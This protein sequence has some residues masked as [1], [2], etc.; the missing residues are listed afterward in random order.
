M[1]AIEGDDVTLTCRGTRYLYDRLSW[2]DPQ[3]RPVG[4]DGFTQ[5]VDPYS[6]S[7]SLRLKNVSRSHSTGYQCRAVNL[8]AGK[9]VNITSTLI[10]H[11]EILLPSLR[12][13]PPLSPHHTCLSRLAFR[14][15]TSIS[16]RSVW[17]VYL[18]ATVLLKGDYSALICPERRLPILKQNLTSQD[19]NSSS[20]LTLACLAHGVPRPFITWYKDK[21]LVTEGPGEELLVQ[22]IWVSRVNP[23]IQNS[24]NCLLLWLIYLLYDK[25]TLTERFQESR[26]CAGKF[27]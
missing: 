19:V 24:K 10:I 2:H 18:M 27:R 16:F 22:F 8:K 25:N 13:I 17:N 14:I 7:L 4:D 5:R 9:E 26:C 3:N 12:Q 21:V 20:T 23:H 1:T 11:G 15:V 6:V